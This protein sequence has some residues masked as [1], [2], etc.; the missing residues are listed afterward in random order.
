VHSADIQDR[1][2]GVLL[3]AALFGMY[4]FLLKLYADA[5]YQ[6]PV[7]QTALTDKILAERTPDQGATG[8]EAAAL[9]RG[10]REDAKASYA[11]LAGE[12]KD[13]LL[14]AIYQICWRAGRS[15]R[16]S[17]LG[18]AQISIAQSAATSARSRAMPPT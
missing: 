12:A 10:A 9:G 18:T 11:A 16:N 8:K 14:D 3:M 1:D 5:G 6:G 17:P 2:G 7:F 15:R 4:P 13:T